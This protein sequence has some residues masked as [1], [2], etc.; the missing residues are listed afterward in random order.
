MKDLESDYGK[1][2]VQYAVSSTRYST[3]AGCILS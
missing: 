3:R 1:F 2:Q